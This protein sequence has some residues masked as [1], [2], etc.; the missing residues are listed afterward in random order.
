[1]TIFLVSILILS[2]ICVLFYNVYQ[3]SEQTTATSSSQ[4]NSVFCSWFGSCTDHKP[5]TETQVLYE[6]FDRVHLALDCIWQTIKA[7]LQ[8]ASEWLQGCLQTA[9]KFPQTACEWLQGSLPFEKITQVFNFFM[10][11]TGVSVWAV[12]WIGCFVLWCTGYFSTPKPGTP[13]KVPDPVEMCALVS[14]F[15]DGRGWKVRQSQTKQGGFVIT[16]GQDP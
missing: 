3:P 6:F 1:M 8:A 11:V 14:K 9:Y 7:F 15:L 5:E 16:A 4:D 10:W 13:E 12:L 2:A